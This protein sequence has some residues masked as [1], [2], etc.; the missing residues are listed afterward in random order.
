MTVIFENGLGTPLESWKP[1]QSKIEEFS[2]VCSYDRAGEG[3]SDKP[4]QPQTPDTIAAELRSLLET[5]KIPGPRTRNNL[6]TM[7]RSPL[8]LRNATRRRMA[9][10]IAVS[11]CALPANSI[12]GSAGWLARR[13]QTR[14]CWRWTGTIFKWTW[15]A[16]PNTAN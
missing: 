13:G 9:G 5:G 14:T 8:R 11:F 10:S 2:R 7:P 6:A 12:L 15:P 3:H 1:V 4:R 16:D